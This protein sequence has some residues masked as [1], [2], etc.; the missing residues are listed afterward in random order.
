MSPRIALVVGMLAAV[1][2]LASGCGTA[3]Q[4]QGAGIVQVT[5][6][7]NPYASEAAR[8]IQA[9]KGGD[10]DDEQGLARDGAGAG[11]MWRSPHTEV[12]VTVDSEMSDTEQAGEA[13]ATPKTEVS[14]E[15]DANLTPGSGG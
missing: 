1:V 13:T 6:Q 3:A 5:I 7:T 15:V 8:P 4:R 10:H 9:E 12:R 14:P 2:V 11:V